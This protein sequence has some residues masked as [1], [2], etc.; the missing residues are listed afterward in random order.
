MAASL[1]ADSTA[2]KNGGSLA[3][4]IEIFHQNGPWQRGDD[5]HGGKAYPALF[6]RRCRAGS[7][8]HGA[9]LRRFL[10]LFGPNPA[11]GHRSGPGRPLRPDRSGSGG[12]TARYSLALRAHRGSERSLDEWQLYAIHYDFGLVSNFTYFLEDPVN[13]D[14]FEQADRRLVVGG[15]LRRNWSL[16]VAGRPLDLAAGLQL[17]HD[18]IDN[19]LYRTRE[20]QRLRTVRE[21]SIMQTTGGPWSEATVSLSP[22]VRARLGLRAD[23]YSV[24]VDSDLDLN[25]GSAD[26]WIFS[27]KLALIFGPWKKTEVYLNFGAGHHSNDA[28]GAVI[29]VDPGTLEAVRRVDPLVRSRGI[30]LGVRSTAIPGLHSTLTVFQL[31]LDSELLFVGDGGSTEASRPSPP[32]RRRVDQF[33]E[34]CRGLHLRFRPHFYRRR[35]PGRRSGRQGNPGSGG[36]YAG[37]RPDLGRKAAFRHAALALFRWWRA[38]RRRLGRGQLDL[39]AQR[40]SWLRLL[41]ATT[42]RLSRCSTCSTARPATSNTSTLRG[43]PASPKTASQTFIFIRSSAA[44]RGCR[45]PGDS[46]QQSGCSFGFSSQ[47]RRRSRQPP[48]IEKNLQDRSVFLLDDLRRQGRD[49]FSGASWSSSVGCDLRRRR[50]GRRRS[51]SKS[52]PTRRYIPARKSALRRAAS[53][54]ERISA[55]FTLSPL[56]F[57]RFWPVSS[58]SSSCASSLHSGPRGRPPATG[59]WRTDRPRGPGRAPIEDPA[60]TAITCR[61][62]CTRERALNLRRLRTGI[63]FFERSSPKCR[64]AR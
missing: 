1:W 26:D 8:A 45:W 15:S 4:A 43:C 46:E 59:R 18:D 9:G 37:R 56:C 23:L 34:I 36:A 63:S 47:K 19:G 30:D 54:A 35:V 6:G 64:S 24:D 17:R 3:S 62:V 11:A 21:D 7:H 50:A 16:S 40:P 12:D 44:R 29:R 38:D 58:R 32:A 39:A 57:S 33:L 31:E 10:A 28:R 60:E 2:G 20:L 49:L 61:P 55:S 48:P 13:G 14:Q 53:V 22:H 41:A 52:S 42:A 5:Y 27:P 51:A 25:S